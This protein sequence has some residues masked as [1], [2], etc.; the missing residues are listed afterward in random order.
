MS[1]ALSIY[2]AGDLFDHKDLIGNALLASY[3]ERE[4]SD[5]YTCILPQ[6]LEQSSNRKEH[7][8][9][10]DLKMVMEADLGLF[11][12]DGPDLDSGT[13]VEF[14]VAKQLDIP[15]VIL[16][17]DFRSAGDQDAGGDSWNLMCSF[18]PRNEVISLNGMEWYQ[19]ARGDNRPV[20]DTIDTLYTKLAA[21]IIDGFEVARATPSLATDPKLIENLYQWAIRF[22]GAGLEEFIGNE[23]WVADI[24]EK[25]KRKGL[26]E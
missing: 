6:D 18:Y 5:Q 22:P 13:V 19:N 1:D 12:F 3:I 21:R 14:I 25:K 8:R 17:S 26:F 4:S 16:R 9:N 2:F 11:N 15:T 23:N 24:I 10:Q 7:I 20:L